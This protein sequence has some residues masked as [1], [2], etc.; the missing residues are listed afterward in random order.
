MLQIFLQAGK[1]FF[2]ESKELKRFQRANLYMFL[3][4]FS[5]YVRN[6]SKIFVYR[7]ALSRIFI[8]DTYIVVWRV[9][10]M[11]GNSQTTQIFHCYCF[12]FLPYSAMFRKY[13]SCNI[14]TDKSWLLKPGK[15]DLLEDWLTQISPGILII[16]FLL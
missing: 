9:I 14:F 3:L 10:M 7:F 16:N 11:K 8:C 2:E 15:L 4:Y 12:S 1:K 13:H 6:N 5:V